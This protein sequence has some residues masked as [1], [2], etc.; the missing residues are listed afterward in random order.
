[1][2]SDLKRPREYV[3]RS[4]RVSRL[5][6]R[7]HRD[8]QEELQKVVRNLRGEVKRL[9][10]LADELY[11]QMQ[12]P[13]SEPESEPEQMYGFE[14]PV[15]MH[16]YEGYGVLDDP[17]PVKVPAVAVDDLDGLDLDLGF[18]DDL[19]FDFDLDG[20]D[21]DFDFDLDGIEWLEGLVV[22]APSPTGVSDDLS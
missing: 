13:E 10:R 19:D 12:V 9:R 5:P 22:Q 4:R 11:L 18:L 14:E 1:M 17:N 7:Y 2:S 6:I 8:P 20:F 3:T 21:L 16:G 15:Q